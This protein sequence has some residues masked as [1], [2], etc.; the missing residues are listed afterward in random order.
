MK[1]KKLSFNAKLIWL[2]LISGLSTT[3]V[4]YMVVFLASNDTEP[5]DTITMKSLLPLAFI[6]GLLLCRIVLV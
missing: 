2:T 3:M 1:C 4:T 5:F 6:G